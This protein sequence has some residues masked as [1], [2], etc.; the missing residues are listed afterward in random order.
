MPKSGKI[1]V[2]YN[3]KLDKVVVTITE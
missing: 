3:I 1:C 2:L